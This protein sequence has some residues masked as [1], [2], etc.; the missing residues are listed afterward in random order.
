[1]DYKVSVV[2][3]IFNIFPYLEDCIN[4]ILEQTYDNIEIVLVDDGS[5][6]DSGRL[7]EEYSEKYENI[8]VVHQVNAGLGMA[9]NTGI[10][11]AKGDYI[12][13]V[14]GDDYISKDHVS[15]LMSRIIQEGTDA[16]YG[17]YQQQKGEVF[18]EQKNPL[19]GLYLDKQRILHEFIPR[20]C[21][22]LDYHCVDE[23]PMSVCMSIYSMQILKDNCLLFN[24]E[25]KLISEDF[26]FNL[27]FLEHSNSISVS[28]SCG[29]FYRNN[30]GSLTK[31]YLGDRLMKQ[32]D[33][34]KYIIARTKKIRCL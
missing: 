5:T 14:D 22:K 7:C 1:M 33:F 30:E 18:I 19:S 29:Y 17:G 15:N 13:F 21:G 6:D 10:R 4:S 20:M 23:V 11:N 12:C 31:K 27:D 16:C 2:V 32:I 9:R 26:V 34:T 25:R 24:S 28:E 8:I 3:P